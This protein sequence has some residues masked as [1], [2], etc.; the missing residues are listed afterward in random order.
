MNPDG[1]D[2]TSWKILVAFAREQIQINAAI[3]EV[4]PVSGVHVG[5]VYSL[6]PHGSGESIMAKQLGRAKILDVLGLKS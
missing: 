4:G 3:L 6:M 2:M 5:S 1:T